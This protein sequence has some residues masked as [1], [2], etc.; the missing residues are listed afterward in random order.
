VY[1]V[2][3]V[4]YRKGI[5]EEYVNEPRMTECKE[6]EEQNGGKKVQWIADPDMASTTGNWRQGNDDGASAGDDDTHSAVGNS[7]GQGSESELK[8]THWYPPLRVPTVG[9]VMK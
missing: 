8:G 9:G 6:E 2:H 3:G 4:I 5:C 1:R 7:T